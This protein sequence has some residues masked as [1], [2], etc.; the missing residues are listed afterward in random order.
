MKQHKIILIV[1]GLGVIILLAAMI[2][3][4]GSGINGEVLKESKDGLDA[5]IE[6]SGK[7]AYVADTFKN[8]E[9]AILNTATDAE[10][11]NSLK[12]ALA[13]AKQNALAIRINEWF[14]QNCPDGSISEAISESGKFTSPNSDLAGAL[15]QYRDYQYALS[16]SG[17]LKSFLTKEYNASGHSSLYAS[18]SAALSGQR[19]RNCPMLSGKLEQMNE[20]LNEFKDFAETWN[21]GMQSEVAKG[22]LKRDIETDKDGYNTKMLKY[23]YYASKYEEIF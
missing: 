21:G 8:I 23:S 11:E 16:F 14:N 10:H 7:K 13:I 12:Q 3:N 22:Y 20:E 9:W 19:F 2:Y 18:F 4:G 15:K 6:A 5:R 1:I 17:K